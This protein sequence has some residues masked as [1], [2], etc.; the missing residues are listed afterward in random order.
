MGMGMAGHLGLA[1]ESAW[2]TPV[3][4]TSGGYVEL[5]SES[6]VLTIDRFDIKNIAAMYAEADD[7]A[8]INKVAGDV[9]FP[10]FPEVLGRFL[11][12]V[13]GAPST[14]TSLAATLNKN[15]FKTP[16]ADFASG[17]P[18]PPYTF[19]VYRDVTSAQQI[20]GVVMTSL[21]LSMKPNQELRGKVGIIG[22]NMLNIAK[23][24]PTYISSPSF[25][26]SFDTCS[27]ALGSSATA[28]IEALTISID[29]QLEGISALNA[30]TAIAKVRRSG[31]QTVNISGTL[32]FSDITEFNNFL[33]QTEQSLQATFTKANS[34]MVAVIVPRMVYTAFPVSVGDKGRTTVGFSGK[35]RYHTG[36]AT[37]IAIELTTTSSGGN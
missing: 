30:S 6:M 15:I 7:M 24:T 22:K 4:V 31:P 3:A 36:S 37:A 35:G 13:F 18:T 11:R 17:Q 12:G 16:T 2:G 9:E 20:S 21:E 1:R 5:L 26:F 28:L 29:N 32:D 10:C 33:N 19:E 34:F 27:L 25:P 23:T 14:V 8:G